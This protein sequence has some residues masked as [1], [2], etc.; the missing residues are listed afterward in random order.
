MKQ[1]LQAVG[2]PGFGQDRYLPKRSFD[3]LFALARKSLAGAELRA[4]FGM[5]LPE[6]TQLI[7]KLQRGYL[8]DFVSQADG[9]KVMQTLRLTEQG[10]LVLLRT[11]ERM[12]ELPEL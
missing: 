3:V 2:V 11:L 5:G 4:S 12:C 7:E 9:E 10:E 8:V 6:W 1:K